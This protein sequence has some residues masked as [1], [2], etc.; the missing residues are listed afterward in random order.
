MPAP[1]FLM[2]LFGK[3]PRI[4]G[5]PKPEDTICLEFADWLRKETLKG[6]LPFIWCHVPNEFSGKTSHLYGALKSAMGRVKGMSDY[7]FL[8]ANKSFV[9]EFKAEGKKQTEH[10][11]AVQFWCEA[12]D[13]PYYLCY[14]AEEGRNVVLMEREMGIYE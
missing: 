11:V 12:R 9:I 10:Q 8:G 2:L 14:T 3:V 4:G 7:V 1:E 13:V 6:T 5:K